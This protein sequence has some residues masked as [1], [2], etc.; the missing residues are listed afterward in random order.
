MQ[1]NRMPSILGRP[2]DNPPVY[3]RREGK[4]MKEEHSVDQKEL[5]EIVSAKPQ[6]FA[7]FLGAG[8][9][10]SAGLPSAADILWD[11][12]RHY[13]CREENQEITR[14]DIQNDAVRER[15]QAFMESR[16]FPAEWADKE[17]ETYFERLFA[18]NK[19]KQ[20]RYLIGQLAEDKVRLAAGHRVLGAMI[21]L[22]LCR[23]AFTTNFDTVVEKSVA[24]MGGKSCS[25]YHLE[26]AHNAKQALNNEEY[27]FYCKLHGDFRYE[28]LKNL[29]TD[30][31]TQNEDLSQCF[32]NAGNRF[33]FVV[34]GYSGRDDS[35]IALF[36]K[37]LE[38][39]NPFPHGLYWTHLKGSLLP[40]T[41]QELISVARAKNVNAGTI[42]IETYDSMMMRLWRNI[43]NKTQEMDAK[44]RRT[45]AAPV[46][47]PMPTAGKFAPILR[48]NALP[49]LAVPSK[50]LELSF[51]TAKEW[52]D[53]RKV[54]HDKEL[55]A[56][57]TKA[58]TVWCW[59]DEAEV[60]SAFGS[61]LRFVSERAVPADFSAPGNLHVHGFVE[62]A[63]C[64]ALARDRPLLARKTRNNA[65]LIIDSKAT[66]IGAFDPLFRVIGKCHGMVEG[67][68]APVTVEYPDPTKVTWAEC[69]RVSLDHKEGRLWLQLEPDVWIWPTR[70]RANAIEF[71][72]KRRGNRYNKFYNQLLNAWV[73]IIFASGDRNVEIE[74]SPFGSGTEASN[75][76]FKLSNRTAFSRRLAA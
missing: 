75:P 16:G 73:Q 20:R 6:N 42:A 67:A 15:I 4:G 36:Q 56:I 63:L 51:R 32:I 11:L 44:V 41:V 17:Y 65:V 19:E 9:S 71:L 27:P 24:A 34:A 45:A 2:A 39:T 46:N 55:D 22:G 43:E 23:V 25:A 29:P 7:W 60:R 26:G 48:L 13:Y 8:A 59:G 5:I 61:D 14:Q 68:F 69:V 49:V 30:L 53:L 10:R 74:V 70:A 54:Q 72:D 18:E 62:E 64:K 52:V 50:C 66:D 38:T 28:S 12:K 58:E 33:G 47:I 3:I 1:S 31:A 57:F 40:S 21:S 37:I 76:K 35:I